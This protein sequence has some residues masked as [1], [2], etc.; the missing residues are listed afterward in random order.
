[1]PFCLTAYGN[2]CAVSSHQLL[3]AHDVDTARQRAESGGGVV[4]AH[5]HARQVVHGL[6]VESLALHRADGCRYVS[7]HC[8]HAHGSGFITVG[9]HDGAERTRLA[10]SLHAAE[11]RAVRRE[12]VGSVG[13]R[14]CGGARETVVRAVGRHA[15]YRL[16]HGVCGGE[17]EF[18][19]AQVITGAALIAC[20]RHYVGTVGKYLLEHIRST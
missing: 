12:N 16:Y 19:A 7:A 13:R 9:N 1:M 4:C 10:A 18:L 8:E 15:L 6:S 11:R 17:H 3:A 20:E 14:G 5:S 2:E